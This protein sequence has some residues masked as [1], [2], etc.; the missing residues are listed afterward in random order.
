[1]KAALNIARPLCAAVL[2]LLALLLGGCTQMFQSLYLASY[3][4]DI[5]SSTRAVE[6]AR[7]NVK[8]AA[9]YTKRGSAY[10]EKARYSRAFKLI[11]ADEYGRLFGLAIKDHDRALALDPA[12]A[13]AY[14]WRGQT[15]YDRAAL[16]VVV[17]GILVVKDRATRKAWFDPA[18][19]DFKRAIEKDGRNYQAWDM[20][21]LSHEMAGELD[22][23]ISAYTQEMALNPKLGRLRL[24]DAYCERA[25]AHQ[26]EMKDAAIADYEKSIDTGASADGCSC[27]P[28]NPLFGLYTEDRR[29]DQ[30]WE[31]VHKARSSKKWIAPELL[32]RLKKESGR[33]D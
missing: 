26:K 3:D 7:D 18:V 12:S 30:A 4:R 28:Y 27:D 2:L 16:E 13:E 17:D 32:D 6:T 29:Y 5:N 22:E 25:G 10:S 23:A 8:R 9:A 11:S 33:S 19:A 24:A 21:G 15:Y 20:L 31:I 14:Y 1:M